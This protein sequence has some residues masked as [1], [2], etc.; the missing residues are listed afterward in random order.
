MTVLIEGLGLVFFF[1]FFFNSKIK[2]QDA[3]LHRYWEPRILFLR[4]VPYTVWYGCITI[5]HR[6]QGDAPTKEVQ[7][8]YSNCQVITS[9][10]KFIHLYRSLLLFGLQYKAPIHI[11]KSATETIILQ[12]SP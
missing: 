7:E 11:R 1:F 12:E 9:A 5:K 8:N 2:E 10:I 3:W 6:Y 4:S